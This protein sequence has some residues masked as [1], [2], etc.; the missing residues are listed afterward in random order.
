MSWQCTDVS[1]G[2]FMLVKAFSMQSTCV[3]GKRCVTENGWMSE[4]RLNRCCLM[5]TPKDKLPEN[6]ASQRTALTDEPLC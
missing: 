6:S 5:W 4:K 3:H 1:H 2:S